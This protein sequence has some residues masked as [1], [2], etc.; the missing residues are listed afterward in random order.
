MTKKE[1]LIELFEDAIIN[2]DEFVAVAVETNGNDEYEI[3]INPRENFEKKLEYYKNSYNDDLVLNTY[4][5]IKIVAAVEFDGYL[6]FD[7][8]LEMLLEEVF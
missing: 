5:A 8:I 2:D 1:K 4:N 3:I 6:M 7:D